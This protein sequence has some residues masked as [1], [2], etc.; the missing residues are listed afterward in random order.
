MYMNVPNKRSEPCFRIK[1][2][3]NEDEA[4]SAGQGDEGE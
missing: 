1:S 2:A 3:R 4:F